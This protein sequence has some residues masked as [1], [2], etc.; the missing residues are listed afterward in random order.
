MLLHVFSD[1]SELS[2]TGMSA[3]AKAAGENIGSSVYSLRL[4]EQAC[5]LATQLQCNVALALRHTTGS[6]E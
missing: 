6:K 5:Q 2:S 1:S 4:D 3:C